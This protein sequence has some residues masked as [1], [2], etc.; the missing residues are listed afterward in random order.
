MQP[1]RSETIHTV[2]RTP[3]CFGTKEPFSGSI[4]NK[5][6]QAPVHQSGKVQCRVLK[7]SLCRPGQAMRVPRFQDNQ[8][9]K[10]VRLSALGIGCLY[11][12]ENI[13]STHFHYRPNQPQG[14]VLLKG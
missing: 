14:K 10:L 13:P 5:G 8:H 11:T 12:P 1:I 4:T 3:T 9:I 6:V 2:L 7:Q